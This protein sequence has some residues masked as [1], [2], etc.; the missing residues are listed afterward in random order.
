MGRVARVK[1]RNVV[2]RRRVLVNTR[3][4][5][6]AISHNRE[7]KGA[8]KTT[9]GTETAKDTDTWAMATGYRPHCATGDKMYVHSDFQCVRIGRFLRICRRQITYFVADFMMI[10]V[11]VVVDVVIVTIV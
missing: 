3:R 10:M 2:N 4:A 1:T 6:M 8:E 5:N 11:G 9:N 7:L